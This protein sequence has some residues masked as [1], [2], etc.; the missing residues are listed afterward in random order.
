MA[1]VGQR[2]KTLAK[3]PLM[4]HALQRALKAD[5]DPLAGRHGVSE[6]VQYI[7]YMQLAE[8]PLSRKL[9]C[10]AVGVEV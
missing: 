3:C 7:R 8:K 1:P 5:D 10:A 6:V 4:Q 2:S 9:I